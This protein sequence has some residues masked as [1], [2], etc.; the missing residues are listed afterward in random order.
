MEGERLQTLQTKLAVFGIKK[1]Q[2]ALTIIKFAEAAGIT[3][4]EL[5][6]YTAA[7]LKKIKSGLKRPA[8]WPPPVKLRD[9]R[10]WLKTLTTKERAEYKAWRKSRLKRSAFG[11]K[12][13]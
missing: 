12:R 4:D 13:P 2:E 10:E 8:W 7:H 9:R 3:I 1:I 6:E 11:R 5:R